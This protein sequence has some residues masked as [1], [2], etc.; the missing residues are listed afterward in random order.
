MELGQRE[1]AALTLSQA[2]EFYAGNQQLLEDVSSRLILMGKP[3]AALE[4]T[5]YGAI[6]FAENFQLQLNRADAFR[7]L[8]RHEEAIELL[9]KLHDQ[10]PERTGVVVSL[11]NS[12]RN[13]RRVEDALE[14]AE[15]YLANLS[16]E[17][18]EYAG[19]L[20]ELAHCQQIKGLHPQAFS[21]ACRS[22]ELVAATPRA[23]VVDGAAL[24]RRIDS[25]QRWLEENGLPQGK[26]PPRGSSVRLAFMVGF[27]RSGTTLL[28]S[29]LAAHPRVETSR[30]A[31]LIESAITS[32]LP[33]GTPVYMLQETI[34]R[35]SER[36]LEQA[37]DAYWDAVAANFGS[38]FD[39][40]ID[41]QPLNIIELPL[42][43]TLFPDARIILSLR[44][45]RDTCLSC[46]FQW[47]ALTPALKPFL[48]WD[49]TVSFYA[50]VL[51][52]WA[53]LEPLIGDAVYQLKYEELTADFPGQIRQLTE[54]LELDWDERILSYVDG[55]RQGYF[56]TPSNEAVRQQVN[57]SAVERWRQYPAAMEAAEPL[58]GPIIDRLGYR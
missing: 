15:R 49:T 12:L 19:L 33:S 2:A 25:Y 13:S 57:Q 34:A 11:V 42:I 26:A 54:Y 53:T 35:A 31:P 47:F 41:K 28:E 14:L 56:H 58:L 21:S 24:S 8:G 30:E 10:H 45:P 51:E 3:A 52:Y 37:R 18:L 44:D 1:A 5:R 16:P 22:G 46:L 6:R 55:N 23:A 50:R 40:F 9:R 20:N 39:F 17:G 36:E 32:L 27:P 7:L 4:A 48:Q 38:D 29:M 43:R